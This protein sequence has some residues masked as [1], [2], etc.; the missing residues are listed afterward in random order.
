MVSIFL[1]L[2]IFVEYKMAKKLKRKKSKILQN[3]NPDFVNKLANIMGGRSASLDRK[4][5]SGSSTAKGTA[6]TTKKNPPKK[7]SYSSPPPLLPLP[8]VKKQV[9]EP[10][11]L[12]LPESVEV[13]EMGEKSIKSQEVKIQN[14]TQG[15]SRTG[16]ENTWKKTINIQNTDLFEITSDSDELFLPVVQSSNVVISNT[17]TFS[18]IIAIAVTILKASRPCRRTSRIASSIS[19][20]SIASHSRPSRCA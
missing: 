20:A 15:N 19:A 17:T 16:E 9:E 5:S 8:T 2:I 6:V 18:I 12:T 13:S 1:R 14:V 3:M 11:P 4:N 10:S 7:K